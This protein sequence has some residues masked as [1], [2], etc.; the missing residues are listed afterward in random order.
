MHD[1]REAEFE[2]APTNLRRQLAGLPDMS[3]FDKV[4]K[5]AC[6]PKAAPPKAKVVY[7]AFKIGP[8]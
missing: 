2:S 3:S 1:T 5:L 7:R 6:K 8:A 4:V